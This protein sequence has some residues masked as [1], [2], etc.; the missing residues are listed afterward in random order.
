MS[1]PWCGPARVRLREM[2]LLGKPLKRMFDRPPTIG[3]LRRVI[4]VCIELDIPVIEIWAT[5]IRER[6]PLTY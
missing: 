3:I 6:P 2:P 5:A 1:W 4:N